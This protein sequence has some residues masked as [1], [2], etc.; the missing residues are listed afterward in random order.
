MRV[1]LSLLGAVSVISAVAAAPLQQPPK[2]L[3]R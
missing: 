2:L 3:F 1:L